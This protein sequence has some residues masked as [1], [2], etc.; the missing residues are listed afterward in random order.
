ML[1][2]ILSSILFILLSSIATA[3]SIQVEYGFNIFSLEIKEDKIIY[4]KKSYQD[5]VQVKE[6]S[7]K[8]FNNFSRKVTTLF[9]Q[10]PKDAHNSGDFMIKY[11]FD[12]KKGVLSPHSTSGKKLLLLPQEFETF[13]LATEFRCQDQKN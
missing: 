13:R 1:L 11:Q 5:S 6:C 8:L 12:S 2:K 4:Q 7:K 10:L 9:K 3:Q